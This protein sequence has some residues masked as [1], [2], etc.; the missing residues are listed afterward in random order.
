MSWDELEN[1]FKLR[2]E[3]SFDEI[4]IEMS[5]SVEY[6]QKWQRDFLISREILAGS[7]WSSWQSMT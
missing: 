3:L 1:W 5:A 7:P 4:Q 6:A 2:A